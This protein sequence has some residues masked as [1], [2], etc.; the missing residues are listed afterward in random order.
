MFEG[1]FKS[2]WH[3]QATSL[4]QLLVPLS[5]FLKCFEFLDKTPSSPSTNLV[6][7]VITQAPME[8]SLILKNSPSEV[9]VANVTANGL[10][11]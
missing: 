11:I 2:A 6:V 1:I 9:L 5:G 7:K 4:K 8:F 10:A 3:Q